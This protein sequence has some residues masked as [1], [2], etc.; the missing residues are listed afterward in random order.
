MKINQDKGMCDII[1]HYVNEQYAQ[2]YLDEQHAQL[3]LD[4][5]HVQLYLTK[6]SISVGFDKLS[7]A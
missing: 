5:Q 1:L 4:E 3:Y 7:D 6:H 2:L